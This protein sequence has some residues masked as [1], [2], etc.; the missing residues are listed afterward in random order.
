MSARSFSFGF[1]SFLTGGADF[2]GGSAESE[3]VLPKTDVPHRQQI[4]AATIPSD[5]SLLIM[6]LLRYSE[7]SSERLSRPQSRGVFGEPP[8]D[9][10]S[11]AKSYPGEDDL[12]N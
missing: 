5:N 11:I 1:A 4:N 7:V 3:P 9:T 8:K 12:K 2:V 10:T 6:F